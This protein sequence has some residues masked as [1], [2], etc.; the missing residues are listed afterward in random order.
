VTYQ[1]FQDDN[2][3]IG[4]QLGGQA[5]E[6]AERKLPLNTAA[7]D[8]PTERKNYDDADFSP[9][10]AN[11]QQNKRDRLGWLSGPQG[12]LL[13]LALGLG[14]A[15]ASTRLNQPAA[16]PEV[17]PTAAETPVSSGSVTTVR[18]Q[19]A[20]VKETI[21]ASG[22]VAAFDLLSVSPRASGLQIQ[23]VTVRAGDRVTA[24]QVLAT[25]DDSILRA[26][27]EQ[28]EAQ[29]IA[30][31][32]D[33]AQEEARAAQ[34]QATAAEAQEKFDRYASLQAQGAVSQ[35][36][37]ATLRTELTTSRESIG[38]AVAAINSAKANV[39]SR[40]AEV[41]QLYTQLDQTQVLAPASGIIAEKT[42]TVGDTATTGTPLFKL[43]SGDQ[44][45]LAVELAQSQL[46]KINVG[47]AVQITASADP[48]L[49]LQG[50][51]QSIDPTLEAQS[52]KATVKVSLPSSDKL[53]PGMF[54]QAAITTG[55]RQGVVVPAEAVVPQASGGFVVYTLNA[56]RTVKA[57]PV[58]I[59]NRTPANGS[60]PA[61]IEISSGIQANVPVVVAGASYLQDGDLVD[62]VLP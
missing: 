62:P 48:N 17:T 57:N 8:L 58:T 12:L 19:S 60:T 4:G 49:Q 13:G 20:P 40:Q 33:V 41:A 55:S 11:D 15:F 59:G 46:A 51:V 9:Q 44:L 7:Y 35:E 24:G 50:Q 37:L 21:S 43:I 32:A 42:A 18:A 2:L 10:K 1:N 36:E 27:I 3:K 26:Q 29:V 56:D 39:R 34:A 6:N 53:R 23:A 25:L 30:A 5:G 22:T 16:T 47:S 38:S 31:Q 45:E 54:L 52:R 28:A 14:I 61:K